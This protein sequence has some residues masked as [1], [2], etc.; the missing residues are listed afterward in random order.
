MGGDAWDRKIREQIAACALFVPI[1]SANTQARKEGYFRLE[2]K[3]AEDRSH[4]MA[5]GEPFI[6]P[7]SIDGTTERGALVP[8]A[9]TAVQWTRLPEGAA[10]PQ[11]VE[12][13]KK[14]LA[15]DDLHVGARLVR[16][17][18][19]GRAQ[20]TPLQ[21]RVS[22]SDDRSI[23]VL[24]FANMSS[25]AENEYFCDGIAEE[26][27]R[28]LSKVGQLQVAGRTSAFS[29]KGKTGDLREIGRTLNVGVVLEGSVRKA[30]SRLRITAQLIKVADGYHLWSERFDRELKDIFDIQD[31]IALAVVEA[32][33]VTL[34]GR[35]KAAVLNRPTGNTEAY[36]LCLKARHA[37]QR[38]T[39][40]GFR[41]AFTL[42]NQALAL[43][44]N[45]AL[46][47]FGLGDCYLARHARPG[48]DGRAENPDA[49]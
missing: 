47:H 1:I 18:E 29:F 3:L 41:I 21:D 43:D 32:L 40:G 7:V 30:G 16:A 38:W 15:P 26:I 4:L 2:W 5:K 33:K 8:D 22:V 25:D 39:D 31:E 24:P 37:W 27:T 42:F 23:A 46:A 17:Q 34:L 36:Q 44:P 12:R 48:T 28:A 11:F 45:Y 10:T 6:V 14:L 9:F 20:G 49:D 13:V 19:D 35:E